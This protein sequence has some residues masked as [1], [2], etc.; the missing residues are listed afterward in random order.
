MLWRRGNSGNRVIAAGDHGQRQQRQR[1]VRRHGLRLHPVC[2]RFIALLVKLRREAGRVKITDNCVSTIFGK[3]HDIRKEVK[4]P[5]D[6]LRLR[7]F[8]LRR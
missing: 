1:C 2:Y 4:A 5:I 6:T 3:N 7:M 8:V